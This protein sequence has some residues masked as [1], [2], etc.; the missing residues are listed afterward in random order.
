[1]NPLKWIKQNVFDPSSEPPSRSIRPQGPRP[2]DKNIKKPKPP[3][4]P[5]AKRK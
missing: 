3:K 5:T 4:K 2:G 1:M